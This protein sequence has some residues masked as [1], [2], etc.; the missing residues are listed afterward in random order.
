MLADD[1]GKCLAMFELLASGASYTRNSNARI[2]S[3][4]VCSPALFQYTVQHPPR[5]D[6]R[7]NLPSS[8]FQNDGRLKQSAETQRFARKICEADYANYD[9]LP[10][11]DSRWKGR[12][13]GSQRPGS[14]GTEVCATEEKF[15][16][17]GLRDFRIL[18][19][20]GGFAT[21]SDW[22]DKGRREGEVFA[23]VW[24]LI[25]LG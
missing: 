20:V 2:D 23:I 15:E 1:K 13:G 9:S 11:L 10:S 17:R 18:N 3:F 24:R 8:L 22:K 21:R 5:L 4:P 25:N 7:T 12:E 6:V 14:K 19:V 16:R